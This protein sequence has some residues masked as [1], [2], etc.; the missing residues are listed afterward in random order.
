MDIKLDVIADKLSYAVFP[1]RIILPFDLW[2]EMETWCEQHVGRRG[3]EWE[4]QWA[5]SYSHSQ[6]L[7]YFKEEQVRN[8]F[9]LKWC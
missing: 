6:V 3:S 5:I 1:Y 8:L 9:I 4:T 7:F 2:K